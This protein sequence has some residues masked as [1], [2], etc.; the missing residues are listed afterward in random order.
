MLSFFIE[1]H[2]LIASNIRNFQEK[3]IQIASD[4]KGGAEWQQSQSNTEIE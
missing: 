1:Q 3:E 4:A 2:Y